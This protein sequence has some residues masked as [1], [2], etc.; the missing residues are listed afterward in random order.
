MIAILS[1][2]ASEGRE[3]TAL[4]IARACDIPKS[5]THHL[6]NVL[7]RSQYVSYIGGRRTWRLGSGIYELGAVYLRDESIGRDIKNCLRTL[8]EASDSVS[9]LAML[10]GT[11]I[12]YVDR[13]EAPRSRVRLTTRIGSRLPAHLP[14][15]GLA[16]LS[17]LPDE[18]VRAM[19]DDYAFPRLTDEGPTSVEALLRTIHDTRTRKYAHGNGRVTPGVSCVAAPVFGSRSVPVA[20]IGIAFPSAT[21]GPRTFDETVAMVRSAGQALSR[22]FGGPPASAID[23]DAD[24]GALGPTAVSVR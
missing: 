14:S 4:E 2:L 17:G 11:D 8:A 13:Q 7:R 21:H 15:V 16:V 9:H 12:F 22:V 20:A 5:S 19:Y 24:G 3:L 18:Q 10:H 1:L 23:D 6:L